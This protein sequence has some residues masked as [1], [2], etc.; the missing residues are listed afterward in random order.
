MDNLPYTTLSYSN[1]PG[2]Y[3]TYNTQGG[4]ID[5]SLYNLTDPRHRYP[6]TVPLMSET[7]G[8]ED[9]GIYASGPQSH[10]FVG[11]YEQS[12]IPLLMAHVAE[13]G[14]FAREGRCAKSFASNSLIS[15]TLIITSIVMSQYVLLMNFNV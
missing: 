4:R 1:G 10:M 6:A 3:H 9:V 8:G 5:L 11:T 13:I 2:F 12:Y 7:H 15:T 14:P